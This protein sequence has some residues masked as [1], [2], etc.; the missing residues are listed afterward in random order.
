MALNARQLDW[1]SRSFW[2][3]PEDPREPF[4]VVVKSQN[5]DEQLE[6]LSF[7]GLKVKCARE[8]VKENYWGSNLVLVNGGDIEP[9]ASLAGFFGG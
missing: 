3:P 5:C 6:V 7:C 9:K 2:P 4:G 1:G 8:G